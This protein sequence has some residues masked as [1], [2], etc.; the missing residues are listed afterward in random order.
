ML[1]V[2]QPLIS[3]IVAENGGLGSSRDLNTTPSGNYNLIGNGDGS[4]LT[5][6]TNNNIVG[7]TGN[8]VDPKLGLLADNGGNTRTHALLL[9][10][11]ALDAIP[12]ANCNGVTDQRGETRPYNTNCDIGAYEAQSDPG[13]YI[14]L[15]IVLK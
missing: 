14:Y 11:P 12:A 7:S 6:G 3:T 5:N 1:R 10:S 2:H 8:L 4:G 15:P 9:Y 13:F